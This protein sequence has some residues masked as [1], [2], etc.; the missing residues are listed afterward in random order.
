MGVD[1]VGATSRPWFP[2]IDADACDGCHGAYKCVAL[3]PHG[4]LAVEDGQAVV[5]HPLGCI[6]GCSNCA[7]L[8]PRGAIRFPAIPAARRPVAKATWLRRVTCPGCGKR[9]ATDR[10]TVFCFDCGA[11]SARRRDGTP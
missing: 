7:P 9:F 1:E 2:T 11:R 10:G 5:V 6:D 8:C 3:C 4:V